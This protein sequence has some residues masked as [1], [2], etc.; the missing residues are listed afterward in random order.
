MTNNPSKKCKESQK[1]PVQICI[2]TMP[3]SIED[4]ND[5]AERLNTT[6]YEGIVIAEEVPIKIT[7]DELKEK[8]KELGAE[9][10]TG[11]VLDRT[12]EV[13]LYKNFR[14]YRDGVITFPETLPLDE[15]YCVA[16]ERTY[17]QMLMIMEA[18]K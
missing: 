8:A 11:S 13:I 10:L 18:L 14:F 15:R 4:L 9:V 1:V 3:P 5:A 12:W 7:W 6:G 2:T 17:E 16:D